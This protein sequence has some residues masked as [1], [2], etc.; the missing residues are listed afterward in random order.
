MYRTDCAAFYMTA[1]LNGIFL[2]IRLKSFKDLYGNEKWAMTLLVHSN[3]FFELLFE[4]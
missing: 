3:K 2:I 1:E 4:W